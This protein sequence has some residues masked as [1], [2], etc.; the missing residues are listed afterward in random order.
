[1]WRE[2]AGQPF[3]CSKRFAVNEK[4]VTRKKVNRG[5]LQGS[6]SAAAAVGCCTYARQKNTN[7]AEEEEEEEEIT[8][9]TS[10]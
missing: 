9:M 10:R 3:R 2:S 4:K 7:G 5:H 8:T 1:M 6:R